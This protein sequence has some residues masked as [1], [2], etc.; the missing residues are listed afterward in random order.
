MAEQE[1]VNID[2]TDPEHRKGRLKEYGGS[3]YDAFNA[4]MLNQANA[5]NWYGDEREDKK[6]KG[7]SVMAAMEGIAPKDEIEGMLAAQLVASHSAAMECYRRAMIPD[8]PFESR[9]E[10][11]NQANKLSRSF[12]TLADALNKHRGKGQQKVTVEHVHV[13]QGGQAIVG[14][15]ESKGGINT[16]T[17]GQPHAIG[18]DQSP[19]M[20][21]QNAP[22]DV[23][24]ITRDEERQM[25]DARG[26]VAGGTKRQQERS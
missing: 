11:L 8:Q 9:K 4:L 19:P 3:E 22:G 21:C 14:A 20:P 24:P 15:V 7:R 1:Q 26:K 16:K 12:A 18:H 6:E 10:N 13:Y 23:V 25:Q 17:E 5:A 2:P